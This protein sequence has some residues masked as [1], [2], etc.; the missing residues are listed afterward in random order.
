M[1]KK[2]KS[3][4]SVQVDLF[5]QVVDYTPAYRSENAPDLNLRHEFMGAISYCM[6][7]ARKNGISRERVVE[8]MNLCLDQEEQ[9]TL[10]QFNGWTAK[11]AEYREFPAIYLPAFIWACLGTIAPLQLISQSIGLHITG[12]EE[13]LA[14]E[15]GETVLEKQRLAERERQLRNKLGGKGNG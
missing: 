3:L 11:S 9:I 8:R 13:V 4:T 14:Q 15:L 10:R 7:E 5:Q 1:A 12:E 6:R 2:Q